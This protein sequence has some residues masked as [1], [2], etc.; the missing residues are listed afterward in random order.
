M[1]R[2]FGLI[3][4]FVISI[5][6]QPIVLQA[7]E[8]KKERHYSVRGGHFADEEIKQRALLHRWGVDKNR[9]RIPDLID[10]VKNGKEFETVTVAMHALA[11][12]GVEE[13]LPEIDDI[14]KY[15]DLRLD[16]HP[17][18]AYT[19]LCR[20]RLIAEVGSKDGTPEERAEK[21]LNLFLEAINLTIE[22]IN[23]KAD[24]Q[25]SDG[26]EVNIEALALREIAD[27]IYQSKDTVLTQLAQKRDLRFSKDK[28]ADIKIQLSTKDQKARIDWL[29]NELANCPAVSF[30][31]YKIVQL[32][33]DEGIPASTAAGNKLREMSNDKERY[34]KK[35]GDQSYY[36]GFY[37]V[38]FVISGNG[39]KDQRSLIQELAR[40]SSP[41]IATKALNAIEYLQNEVGRVYSTIY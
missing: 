29:L 7:Q 23:S 21:K 35:V 20:A 6:L 8:V 16:L 30:D 41:D 19:R 28:Y 2:Y 27:M 22:Q 17:Y 12:M 37:A 1:K 32:A 39:D 31:L 24:K 18:P 5:L 4:L 34:E 25:K 26:Q 40:D 36:P 11:R 14:L 38:I 13:I 10:A 9:K 33:I 3:C 15:V